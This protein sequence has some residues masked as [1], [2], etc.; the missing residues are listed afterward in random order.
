MAVCRS[1]PIATDK[2]RTFNCPGHRGL[3]VPEQVMDMDSAMPVPMQPGDVLFLTRHTIHGSLSNHSDDVR[4]SFDL[5]Y[6][7]IGQTTGRDI[8]PGFIAR[9]KTQPQNVL[10]DPVAWEKLWRDTRDRL[11]LEEQVV[12]NRWSADAAVCA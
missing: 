3:R 11:A 7:P 6:N 4:W 1:C 8:F 12:F 5:R 10:S 2:E 9:S